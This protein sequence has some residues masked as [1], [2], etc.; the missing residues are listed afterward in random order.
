[1]TKPYVKTW[2]MNKAQKGYRMDS[3]VP[4][5]TTAIKITRF[6]DIVAESTDTRLHD[7]Y[8]PAMF[9]SLMY[10]VCSRDTKVDCVKGGMIGLQD[11]ALLLLLLLGQESC[12]SSVLE[13]LTDSLICL[14]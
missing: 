7:P 6:I 11:Q 9:P 14:C 10:C 8:H 5:T 2:I 1:M 3:V 13:D 4:L 12:A